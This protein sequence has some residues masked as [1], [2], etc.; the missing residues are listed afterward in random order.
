M[1]HPADGVSPFWA[2][3][4]QL[5]LI[6]ALASGEA[7]KAQAGGVGSQQDQGQQGGTWL[8]WQRVGFFVAVLNPKTPRRSEH[9]T[10]VKIREQNSLNT[11]AFFCFGVIGSDKNLD[12]K[13]CHDP[14]ER[15]I[16]YTRGSP[17]EHVED[18]EHRFSYIF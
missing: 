7:P 11:I 8:V 2:S 9:S 18:V 16:L 6:Q 14:T 10:E 1:N 13:P 17:V 15:L 3:I 12:M 5:Q 4:E